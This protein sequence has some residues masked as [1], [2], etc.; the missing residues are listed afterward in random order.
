MIYLIII[1][2][3]SYNRFSPSL[4]PTQHLYI[5]LWIIILNVNMKSQIHRVLLFLVGHYILFKLPWIKNNKL[6]KKNKK[7]FFLFS[8]TH[9]TSFNRSRLLIKKYFQKKT[10]NFD[11]FF[12]L[13]YLLLL[14]FL[15]SEQTRL[16]TTKQREILI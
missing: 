4:P 12:Q 11:V 14:F 7:L 3:Y 6:T 8:S 13:Q 9:T 5:F 16:M 1:T 15:I 2:V 10:K